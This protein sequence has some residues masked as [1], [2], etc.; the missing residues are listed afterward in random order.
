MTEPLLP[1]L[2]VGIAIAANNAAVSLAL[3]SVAQRHLWPRI[4]AIFGLFE[5]TIPLLG[6][7]LGQHAARLIAGQADWLGPSVL[8]LLGAL[9][10]AGALRSPSARED[11]A[12]YLTGWTGLVAL[13]AGLSVD[14]LVVGFSMGLGGVPPL[15]LATTILVCSVLFAWGG[16]VLGRRARRNWGGLA[17]GISGMILIGLGITA[18]T[19][20]A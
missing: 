5:F 2:L 12:G 1:L 4:L 8:M 6:A 16:L 9:T 11:I 17:G 3:G 10:I 20:W 13:A 15:A 19:G 18:L 14:N 7:W